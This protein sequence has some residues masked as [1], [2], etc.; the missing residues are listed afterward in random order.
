MTLSTRSRSTSRALLANI[1]LSSLL[2]ASSAFAQSAAPVTEPQSGPPEV[3]SSPQGATDARWRDALASVRKLEAISHVGTAY[4]SYVD[5]MTKTKSDIEKAIGVEPN[6]ELSF[7]LINIMSEYENALDLWKLSNRAD[8]SAYAY[9]RVGMTPQLLAL[10]DVKY[11]KVRRS[12]KLS[13]RRSELVDGP[14]AKIWL[15]ASNWT[16]EIQKQID[17]PRK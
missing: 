10:Y 16:T 1:G 9:V 14:L 4:Q 15:R 13:A 12:D 7:Y 8:D 3:A 5:S 6:D 11:K 2:L 17:T